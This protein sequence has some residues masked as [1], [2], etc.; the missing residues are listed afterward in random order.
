VSDRLDALFDG[1][2]EML[3]VTDVAEMFG[4]TNQGVYKWLRQGVIPGYKLGGTWFVLRD[5]LR[6]AL[7]AGANVPHDPPPTRDE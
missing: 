1:R 3:S 4:V 7:Q 6:D 5:E 2:P